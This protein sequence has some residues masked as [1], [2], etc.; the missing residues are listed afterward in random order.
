ME[1]DFCGISLVMKSGKTIP[2]LNLKSITGKK[3]SQRGHETGKWGHPFFSEIPEW[4]G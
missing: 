2:R 3:P 1:P 4:P